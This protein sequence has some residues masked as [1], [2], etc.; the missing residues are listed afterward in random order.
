[1][2]GGGRATLHALRG[3]RGQGSRTRPMRA[4]GAR[5]TCYN[6]VNADSRSRTGPGGLSPLPTAGHPAEG[7]AAWEDRHCGFGGVEREA[8]VTP[9][10]GEEA[11]VAGPP[12]ARLVPVCRGSRRPAILTDPQPRGFRSPV[13]GALGD[14]P[15]LL[16]GLLCRH[17]ALWGRGPRGSIG[18]AGIRSGHRG[19]TRADE[20]HLCAP[21]SRNDS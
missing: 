7:V 5:F 11:R 19:G 20:H 18:D 13:S 8:L 15:A 4:C 21:G 14:E 17:P 2:F 10:S 3:R 9:L 12:F 16:P 6:G 1:M